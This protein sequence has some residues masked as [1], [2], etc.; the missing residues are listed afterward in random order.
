VATRTLCIASNRTPKLPE[1]TRRID[2][3]VHCAP[4]PLEALHP[5]LTAHWNDYL[6][7]NGFTLPSAVVQTY[8]PRSA[9]MAN[10][11][12]ATL[13]SIRAKVLDRAQ[14]AIL[15]CHYGAE[16]VRHPYMAAALSTAANNWLK[17][18][19]L[20]KEERLFGSVV[21]VPH[22]TELA[23][24]EI[25]RVGGD[26]RFV[27]VY[28]PVRSWE[29]YGNRRYWP[30]YEAAIEHDLALGIHYGGLTGTPATPVGGLDNY[31]E[32]YTASTQL[33]ASQVLSLIAEGVFDKYPSLRVCLIESGVT[34]LP[35]W[36][37]K[38]D[39]EWKATRREIPWVRKLP[40]EY[41]RQH[42]RMTAQP[43]DAPEQQQ[44][45][46]EVLGHI[47]SDSMLLYASDF[48]HQHAS[49]PD[50]LLKVLSPEQQEQFL[51]SNANEFY[52]LRERSTSA[53][54]A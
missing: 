29:P 45:L 27:Q 42:F 19:W 7:A 49:D 1:P 23:V 39:T 47:G 22:D 35:T 25:K 43:L 3:D 44:D 41:V 48:P 10:A 52:G 51:F 38:L 16:G 50:Q 8:P 13:D 9:V 33:F 21:V 34:W 4:P 54:P 36:L 18:E 12:A 30:I 5:Y 17:A 53:T 11:P 15:N 28:L 46:R 6:T 31:F 14:Y 32:E 2:A 37:W 20:D 24:Q 26:R 40:S